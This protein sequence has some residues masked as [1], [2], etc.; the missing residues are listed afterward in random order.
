MSK[1]KAVRSRSNTEVIFENRIL[2]IEQVAAM[3]GFSKSHVYFLV[4]SDK[5]FPHYKRGKTL[6][7][8]SD[9][10]FEWI[11]EGAA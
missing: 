11:K 4:K 1:N 3:L 5:T 2:R 7:F 9:E 6:F 8:M 10:I